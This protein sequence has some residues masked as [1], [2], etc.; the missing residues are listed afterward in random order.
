[1]S[2][3]APEMQNRAPLFYVDP[4]PLGSEKFGSWRMKG[5]NAAF[6]ARTMGVPVVLGEFAD[7]SRFYPILFAAG[8]GNGPIILTG[9]SDHNVF[10]RNDQWEDRFYVPG[11]IRRYPF[12]LGGIEGD[13]DRLVLVID[14]ASDFFAPGGTEG[15]PLFENNA[16][17][18]FTKDAMSF[19]ETWQRE[20]LNAAEYVKA[21]R[22]KGLL[23]GKRLDGT[24]PSGR[25]FSING[26][27]T[28]DQ[29]KL[30][31]LDAET[32]VAW[33]RRGWLGA[34]YLHIISLNRVDDLIA[35]AT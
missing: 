33:H 29:Q 26:F 13:P 14:A 7:A 27:E 23:V 20:S 16:P 9:V 1:M 22:D 10:V 8:Q 31:D 4:Q 15:L 18:Q 17:S 11:Y 34:C 30:A 25:K 3:P 5:G 35:R 6:A 28:I 2:V 12:M 32:V 24:L 21:L 19:C